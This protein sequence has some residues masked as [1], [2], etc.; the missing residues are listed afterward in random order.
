[1]QQAITD[2]KQVVK[3]TVEETFAEE[4]KKLNKK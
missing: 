3:E 4:C 2:M 1:M